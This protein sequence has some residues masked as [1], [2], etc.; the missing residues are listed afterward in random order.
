MFIK[1]LKKEKDS[2]QVSSQIEQ[3]AE[4]NKPKK[5][6]MKIDRPDSKNVKRRRFWFYLIS[7]IVI[8]GI[9]FGGRIL[10]AINSMIVANKGSISP[11]LNSLKISPNS[12]KGE[13]DGRIN[14][15][16][17]G[18]GGKN[19]KGGLLAD[20]VMVLSVDSKNNEAA[21][22]S[23]PRDLK[24]PIPKPY[25]GYD[26]INAV[27]SYGEQNKDSKNNKN[28]IDGPEL[29]KQ[30]VSEIFDLPIHYFVRVDFEGFKKI[31]DAFGGITV[32]VEKNLDDPFY[33][34]EQLIGYDPLFIKAGMTKMDG[35][36]ALR[37]ARSRQTTSDF[38]RAK[39]QQQILQMLKEKALSLNFLTNPQ[40]INQ[41]F[42]AVGD[43]IKTDMQLKEMESFA[44][45]IKDI[46]GSSIISYVL[47]NSATGL[48]TNDNEGGYYLVPKDSSWNEIQKK[49]HEIFSDPYLRQED[50][51]IEVINGTGTSGLASKIE[52]EL[53]KYGY[54][55][56]KTSTA[57]TESSLNKLV[58]SDQE[59]FKFTVN[60]LKNR[61]GIS[62]I[63]EDSLMESGINVKLTIGKE[64]ETK[65][66][67]TSKIK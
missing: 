62:Q 17:I 24:V 21:Y 4:K 38:D 64:Y 9:F 14:I 49:V 36:L 30:A 35:D 54:K 22:I 57:E 59:I 58:V 50:A 40:K 65:K 11:I 53:S 7:V 27:H 61:Y 6:F 33:P 37:Y 13:G 63:T 31:V 3:V 29:M 25:G 26:K 15:L 60:Y 18:I 42:S 55:V 43:H 16:I 12:L 20:T 19:H 1:K 45:I 46:N 10:G 52:T 47:D 8:I 2:V 39:R 5:D 44:Q 51:K 34:D 56:V 48:L 66:T 32:N 41:V 23:I 28:N 67:T